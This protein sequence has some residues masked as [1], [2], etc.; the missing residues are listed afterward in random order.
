MKSDEECGSVKAHTV[1]AGV[2]HKAVLIAH[3]LKGFLSLI[4]RTFTINLNQ[5][6]LMNPKYQEND[7]FCESKPNS[8]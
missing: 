7:H 4:L 3:L 2:S 5:L 8:L 1:L 6:F